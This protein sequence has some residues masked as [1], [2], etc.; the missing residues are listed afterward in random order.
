MT[1][2][3]AD[4][5]RATKH[6]KMGGT[7]T[8]ADP[9]VPVQDVALQDQTTPPII[10]PFHRDTN[11][12][13]LAADGVIG[14]R[15]FT[16]ADPTGFT[17]GKDFSV[18]CIPGSRFYRG[19]ITGV[20]GSVITVDSP[21][22]FVYLSGDQATASDS[23]ITANGSVTPVVYRLRSAPPGL[24]LVGD[25]TR[26]IFVMDTTEAPD[27]DKFGDLTL[28]TNGIV[29][30]KKVNGGGYQNIF[31]AK[32]NGD[33]AKIMYDLDF[34]DALKFG[35]HG[36]KG[37]LTFGGQN[38]IGVVIRLEDQDD[39]ELIVQDDLSTLVDFQVIAEGHVVSY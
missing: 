6:L 30:R 9:F 1:L 8:E 7:G 14:Q 35:N 18:F 5:D 33:L 28:L 20:A 31:N 27:L 13:T 2:K 17:V 36:V 19:E 10:M 4:A 24:P 37:R 39:L 38:K 32:S 11:S 21:I 23:H 26:L 25:I 22:D 3:V 15:T 12:T 29:V 34:F 16:V